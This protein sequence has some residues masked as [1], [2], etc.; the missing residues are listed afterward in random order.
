MEGSGSGIASGSVQTITDPDSG[1]LEA[2]SGSGTL[3]MG[4][5]TL[6]LPHP[7]G[8]GEPCCGNQTT[9]VAPGDVLPPKKS[10]KKLIKIV[11]I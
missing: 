7:A 3:I 1:S 10:K 5:E 8:I 4:K 2:K 11:L 6:L 9:F